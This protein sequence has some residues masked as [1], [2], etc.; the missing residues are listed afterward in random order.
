MDILLN[1]VNR[2]AEETYTI[3]DLKKYVKSSNYA[4]GPYSVYAKSFEV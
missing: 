2:K 4:S 3:V 1:S